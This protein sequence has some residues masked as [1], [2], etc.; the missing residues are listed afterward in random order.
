MSRLPFSALHLDTNIHTQTGA[1]C[2]QVSGVTEGM[3][4]DSQRSAARSGFSGAIRG[5]QAAVQDERESESSP[6]GAQTKQ[7]AARPSIIWRS[8]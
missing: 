4:A 7:P 2:I 8:K 5:E 6:G 3:V 1:V